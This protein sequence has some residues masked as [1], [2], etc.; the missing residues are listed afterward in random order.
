MIILWYSEIK[1]HGV[2]K[3]TQQIEFN[4]YALKSLSFYDH[5]TQKKASFPMSRFINMEARSPDTRTICNVRGKYKG[6]KKHFQG[7]TKTRKGAE[8]SKTGCR[9][10]KKLTTKTKQ[11]L[12]EKS[13][14]S[15]N[16]NNTV[17]KMKPV[18]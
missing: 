8:K 17:T 2:K 5:Y 18:L 7:D 4:D 11:P 6:G 16:K 14:I 1:T 15:V 13:K 12:D 10:K 3:K 9:S